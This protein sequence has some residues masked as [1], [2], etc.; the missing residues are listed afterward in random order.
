MPLV[1]CNLEGVILLLCFVTKS[2]LPGKFSAGGGGVSTWGQVRN[3]AEQREDG[4]AD[5]FK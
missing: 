3:T 4:H 2:A 1:G 5:G